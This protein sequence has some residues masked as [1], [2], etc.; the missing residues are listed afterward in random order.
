M[1]MHA[2]SAGSSL[3]LSGVVQGTNTLQLD[4]NLSLPEGTRLKIIAFV[5][6]ETG[7]TEGAN[8]ETEMSEEESLEFLEE[9]LSRSR[10]RPIQLRQPE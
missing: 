6:P 8:H 3:V 5:Q 4:E 7:P 9:L 1:T 2:C 10:G